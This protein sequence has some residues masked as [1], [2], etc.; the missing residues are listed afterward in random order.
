MRIITLARAFPLSPL[1]ICRTTTLSNLFKSIILPI[2]GILFVNTLFSKASS[3][4]IFEEGIEMDTIDFSLECHAEVNLALD[5]D[6]QGELTILNVL[7]GPLSGL[8]DTD[9]SVTVM[10]ADVSNGGIIDGVGSYQYHV[11]VNPEVAVS[12][13]RACSGIINAFDDTAPDILC[14]YSDTLIVSVGPYECTAGFIIPT[15]IVSDNCGAYEVG[16]DVHLWVYVVININPYIFVVPIYEWRDILIYSGVPDDYLSGVE[17]GNGYFRY[18]VTDEYG[19]VDSLDCPFIVEDL[20]LPTTACDQ[21]LTNVAIGSDGVARIFTEDVDE[22]SNDNCSEVVKEIRRLYSDSTYSSWGDFVDF[23]CEDVSQSVVIELRSW[24][25]ANHNGVTDSLDN[26]STCSIAVMVDDLMVPQCQ[27]PANRGFSCTQIDYYAIDWEDVQQ[28]N[29]IFGAPMVEDNCGAIVEQTD[30]LVNIT[31]CGEG[32]VVRTFQATDSWGVSSMNHCEQI[33]TISDDLSASVSD[34]DVFCIE[35]MDCEGLVA[36]EFVVNSFCPIDSL[37]ITGT[38]DLDT[39]GTD[40]TT[41]IISYISTFGD[42]QIFTV[43]GNYSVGSHLFKVDIEDGCGHLLPLEI[44]FEI[45]DC[46]VEAPTCM[47][48]FIVKASPISEDDC[49]ATQLLA[50]DF[51]LEPI[52]DCSGPIQYS[53]HRKQAVDSG[54]EIPNQ[55][56][57]FVTV[58]CN[59]EELVVFVYVYAWD[60]TYNPYS[61]QPDGSLGGPNYSFCESRIILEGFQGCNPTLYITGTI[62]TEQDEALEG[63]EVILGG[64]E[65]AATL[66]SADGVYDFPQNLNMGS[67]SITPQYDLPFPGSGISTFDLV[68]IARH[69][70]GIE[71]LDSPYKLIA[72]DVNLSGTI[73]VL[74][75]IE[76]LGFVTGEYSEFPVND[77]W[78]FIDARYDFPDPTNPWTE[79][80]PEIG[81]LPDVIDGQ[82]VVDFIG[83]PTGDVNGSSAGLDSPDEADRNTNGVFTI[84]TEDI[85]VKAGRSYKVDFTAEDLAKIEGYQF[86]LA[87]DPSILEFTDIEYGIAQAENFGLKHQS[88]GLITTSWIAFGDNAVGTHLFSLVFKAKKDGLLSELLEINSRITSAEAYE[89][90]RVLN[91]A[92]AFTHKDAENSDF[93]VYQ[94]TPNPFSQETSIRFYLPHESVATITLYGLTGEVFHSFTVNGSRGMNTVKIEAKELP[95]A[96]LLFYTVS[97]GVN[98]Q[99]KK[100]VLIPN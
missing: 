39:N 65:T 72:A 91:V 8:S 81:W 82:Y 57:S 36:I 49:C 85:Q 27:A 42:D 29:E 92:F 13:N 11:E 22:G 53:I 54:E 25:D 51:I 24:D 77:F 5:H 62:T 37:I 10:D 88:E 34:Y 59:D 58:D 80:F 84:S 75:I 97:S 2:L 71:L 20:I 96:G 73:T 15:P 90:G 41:A 55:N 95:V 69:I 43:S 6:C 26:S 35:D 21:N 7:E 33:L 4:L 16:I 19:N 18:R 61:I 28:L 74:D 86:T 89:E 40:D 50:T 45:I 63:V 100:M 30:I 56:Q 76:L 12:G 66:T 9:F 46:R 68:L 52:S 1:P 31:D 87:F 99:T 38:V 64:A 83:V 48:S 98:K 70:L 23:D 78:R 67:Y 32:T 44:P 47:E 17:R 14:P 94:N 60:N 3:P 93:E 79:E